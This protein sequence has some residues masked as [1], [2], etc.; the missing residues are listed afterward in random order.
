MLDESSTGSGG[1]PVSVRC[2]ARPPAPNGTS[3]V[4]VPVPTTCR[5]TPDSSTRAGSAV[6]PIWMTS[7]RAG[8]HVRG[9]R[10]LRTWT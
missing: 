6:P 5:W 7:Q 1:M 3:E 2:V 8:V 9:S 4:S 10:P